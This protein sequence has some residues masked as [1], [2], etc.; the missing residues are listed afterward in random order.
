MGALRAS[1]LVVALAQPAAPDSDATP[2]LDFEK[3]WNQAHLHADAGALERL[4][5]DDMTVVVP[6]MEPITKA[7]AV[8]FLRSGRM[9]FDRYETSDIKVRPYG[10]SA[11]VTGRLV[12]VRH[13]GERVLED[14]WR[15]TKVY[16]REGAAWRVVAFHASEAG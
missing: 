1:L 12:R 14:D 5:A 4:W 8:A 6:R 13:M 3:T 15:F 7:A 10:T 2:F 9:Q 11:I 16:V